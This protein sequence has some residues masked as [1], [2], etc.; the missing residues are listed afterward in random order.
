MRDPVVVYPPGQWG[1]FA[2]ELQRALRSERKSKNTIFVY[3]RA[4]RLLGDWTPA[5]GVG[6]LEVQ[7]QHI[8]AFMAELIERTSPGHQP[9]RPMSA[10]HLCNHRNKSPRT[11]PTTSSR[12]CT[13][14]RT[15][16]N[17]D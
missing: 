12:S 6:P 13:T 1:L 8:R 2:R 17:S 11:R 10:H 15:N 3:L 4:V 14:R 7:P 5:A 16:R 9:T